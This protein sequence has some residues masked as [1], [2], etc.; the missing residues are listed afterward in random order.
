MIPADRGSIVRYQ[1]AIPDHT[2]TLGHQPSGCTASTIGAGGNHA[3]AA[4]G[5]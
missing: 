3:S 1:N 2:V 4:V 5:R